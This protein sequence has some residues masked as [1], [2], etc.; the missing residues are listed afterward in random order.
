MIER[1]QYRAGAAR[2]NIMSSTCAL[3]P[4]EFLKGQETE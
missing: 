2:A 1:G 3:F 4:I